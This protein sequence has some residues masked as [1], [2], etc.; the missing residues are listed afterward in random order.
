MITA[1]AAL[2]AAVAAAP[3][4]AAPATL[5]WGA[6]PPPLIERDPRQQCA[7]LPVPLHHGGPDGRTV[8]LVVSRIATAKPGLRRGVL[9]VNLGGPGAPGVDAPS[10]LA[11]AMPAEVT[12]RYDLVGLDPRGVGHSAPISCDFPAAPADV[13]ERYPDADGSIDR[14]VVYARD[15][16]RRCVANGGEVLP[17]V[18]T[19]TWARDMDLVRAALGEARISF[20]GYSYGT[21]LGAVYRTLFPRRADRFVLDS[22][23]DPRLSRYAQLRLVN[24]AASLRLPD[25]TAWA[26]ARDDRYHLGATSA[27]VRRTYDAL[28]AKLDRNPLELPDGTSINGNIVRIQTFGALYADASFP[29]LAEMWAA[30]VAGT[31]GSAL[32][33]AA[34]PGVPYDNMPSVQVA[35]HCNDDRWPR[36][37]ATYRRNVALDRRLFPAFAGHAA[38][39]WPCAFWPLPQREPAVRVGPIGRRNV[40]V[41]QN[42]RDPATPW[43][44]AV[45]MRRALGPDAELLTVDQGGHGAYLITGGACADRTVNAFLAHGDLPD[46]PA[47]CPGRQPPAGPPA[48]GATIG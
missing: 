21:Y 11:A 32:P 22:S 2:C 25:F 28:V 44:G 47:R 43:I 42:L 37:V 29:Q 23:Y 40:L 27:A 13:H 18:T 24:L 3:A 15:L 39:I 26:A 31:A 1:L 5:D 12:D 17:T 45:G 6:C 41:V 16:A 9:L 35:I 10:F 14:N 8:D 33:R 36:D 30:L 19:A 46:A 48:P 4:S 34:Q 38:T 20:L 7:T